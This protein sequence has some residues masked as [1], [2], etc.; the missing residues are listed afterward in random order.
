MRKVLQQSRVSPQFL[1]QIAY[2]LEDAGDI[3]SVFFFPARDV[4]IHIFFS[5]LERFRSFPPNAAGGRRVSRGRSVGENKK[6][7]IDSFV[8][9]LS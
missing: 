4:S 5:Y 2:R 6:R 7:K 1:Y 3:F 8:S 9:R